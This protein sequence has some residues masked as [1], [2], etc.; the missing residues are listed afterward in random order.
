[1]GVSSEEENL[2]AHKLVLNEK[3]E[4]EMTHGVEIERFEDK[5]KGILFSI[6]DFAGFYFL[7]L[8]FYLISFL[9]L[10]SFYIFSLNKN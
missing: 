9:Y 2:N 4:E 8:F 10:I 6:W 1:M 3:R 5:K 7:F